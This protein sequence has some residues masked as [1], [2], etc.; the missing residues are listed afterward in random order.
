MARK[1]D[2]SGWEFPILVRGVPAL[3]K[4]DSS[5]RINVN[6]RLGGRQSRIKASE[7]STNR[8]SLGNSGQSTARATIVASVARLG[9]VRAN[10]GAAFP[11]G[12][13]PVSALETATGP[14]PTSGSRNGAGRHPGGSRPTVPV[15]PPSRKPPSRRK[16]I[17]ETRW[18]R[19]TRG[20][21][22]ASSSLL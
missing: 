18:L 7:N 14:P 19:V 11:A 8:P 5:R 13:S 9:K 17:S 6:L 22:R 16:R 10:G 2:D 20:P 3:L 21:R 4:V 12:A 1:P 15:M